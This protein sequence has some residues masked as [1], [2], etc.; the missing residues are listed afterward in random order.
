MNSEK[1]SAS[2]SE[3]VSAWLVKNGIDAESDAASQADATARSDAFRSAMR[4]LGGAVNI[5]TT[6]DGS[7]R[8]GLTATAV[9]SLTANPPRLLAC[10]NLSGRSYQAI[11]KARCMAVNVLGIQ[12]RE[13]AFAFAGKQ[14]E[15][16]FASIENWTQ[17]ATGAPILTD[18]LAS[19]DCDVEQ[20]MITT[21]HAIVIGDIRHISYGVGGKPLL[22]L[23]GEFMT[24]GA[25]LPD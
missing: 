4:R 16:P 14:G 10:V 23:D 25:L 13:L 6:Q 7:A 12:H 1:I 17:A 9:C 15:D 19:F 11:A 8:F 3:R 18:A 5:V 20:M 21:T 24:S 22:Y 2:V